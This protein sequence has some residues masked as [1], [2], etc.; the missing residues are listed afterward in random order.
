MLPRH[1]DVVRPRPGVP[2][3][4]SVEDIVGS[5][6]DFAVVPYAL[7]AHCNKLIHS[8]RRFFPCIVVSQGR[9]RVV[10]N[11]I[12][13]RQNSKE[14]STVMHMHAVSTCVA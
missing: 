2:S 14:E 8:I 9:C 5:S 4:A 12:S 13:D 7:T 3:A 10:N 1:E 11:W 6:A